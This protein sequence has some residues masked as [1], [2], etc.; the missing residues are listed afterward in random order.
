[1]AT[2]TWEGSIEPAV[3]AEPLETAIPAKSRLTSIAS[4]FVP[5]KLKFNTCGSEFSSDP[6]ISN[7]TFLFSSL[8]KYFFKSLNL[9]LFAVRSSA[10]QF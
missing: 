6:F 8:N 2:R 3:Q 5:G 9:S 10:V 1:M 4:T 7:S